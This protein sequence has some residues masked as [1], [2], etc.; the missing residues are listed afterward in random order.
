MFRSQCKLKRSSIVRGT[1]ET[2]HFIKTSSKVL[3]LLHAYRRTD[4]Q[5]DSGVSVG[6]PQKCEKLNLLSPVSW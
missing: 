2:S 5:M 1:P 3:D 6:D 4:G